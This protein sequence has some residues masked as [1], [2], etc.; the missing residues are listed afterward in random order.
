MSREIPEIIACHVVGNP[1]LKGGPQVFVRPCV[2]LVPPGVE[3]YQAVSLTGNTHGLDGRCCNFRR[4][5]RLVCGFDREIPCMDG[6]EFEGSVG[7]MVRLVVAN[8]ERVAT[9]A[10]APVAFP[11]AARR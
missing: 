4:V 5:N 9:A 11:T 10:G 7:R 2:K 1:S 8:S 6:I 3:Q